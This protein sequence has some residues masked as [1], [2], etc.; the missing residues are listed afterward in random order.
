MSVKL[1][2]AACRV[3]AGYTQRE[4]AEAI[5]VTAITVGNWETGKTVPD[6]VKGAAL[7]ELYGI[8]LGY[9]DFSLEGNKDRRAVK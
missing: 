2:L 8:P 7:S 6:M 3:N 9:M 1:K 4:V 5:G